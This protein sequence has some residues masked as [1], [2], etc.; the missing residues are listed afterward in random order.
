MKNGLLLF[1]SVLIFACSKPLK[2]PYLTLKPDVPISGQVELYYLNSEYTLFDAAIPNEGNADLCFRKDTIPTGFYELRID[3]KAIAKLIIS[4]AMPFSISGSFDLDNPNLVIV[5]NEETKALWKAQELSSQLNDEILN[6]SE[7]I[8]DSILSEK[9]IPTRDSIYTLINKNISTK[10]QEIEKLNQKHR[11]SLLSLLTIQLKAGNHPIFHPDTYIDYY[12]ETNN[13]LTATYPKYKPVAAFSHT[14]DSL[15]NWSLFNSISKEGRKIPSIEIPDAW[16]QMVKIDE[17][18]SIPTL[19]VIWKSDNIEA[20]N[21]TKQLM[22]WTWSYRNRGLKLCMIS[23]DDNQEQWLTA[24]KED[25]L[26]CLHL[27]DLKGNESKVLQQLGLK[28]EPYL[29]LID[30]HKNIVKRA[31]EL[32]ELSF[33][34]QQLMKN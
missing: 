4:S 5:G 20:R 30:K 19:F 23:L 14:V 9:F 1:I 25:H 6:I 18:D 28:Q 17:L 21:I 12:N 27:S 3:R 22:R 11:N 8:P 26:A 34:L 7:A 32:D 24:I 13:H 16:N 31:T 33:S 15:M 10:A 2:T 29:L